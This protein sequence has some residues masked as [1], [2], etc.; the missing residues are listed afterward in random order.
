MF[1]WFFI[2]APSIP[3]STSQLLFYSYKDTVNAS[4]EGYTCW[5]VSHSLIY[6]LLANLQMSVY[7]SHSLMCKLPTNLQTW[8]YPSKPTDKNTASSLDA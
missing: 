7:P 1:P 8:V 4:Q 6:K 2:L 3:A 5:E